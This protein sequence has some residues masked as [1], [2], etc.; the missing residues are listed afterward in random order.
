MQLSRAVDDLT[1]GG[2]VKSRFVTE[3]EQATWQN[4][5]ALAAEQRLVVA[6]EH[7]DEEATADDFGG[8]VT[9]H[10][11]AGVLGYSALRRALAAGRRATR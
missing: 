3:R 2:T 7:V 4:A 9:R 8:T 11:N 1:S 6:L 5:I 10:N